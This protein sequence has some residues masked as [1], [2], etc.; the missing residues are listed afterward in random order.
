MNVLLVNTCN[1]WK[2]RSSM[3]LVGIVE[4]EDLA[5]MLCEMIKNKVIEV[6]AINIYADE[7]EKVIDE[8]AVLD[9]LENTSVDMLNVGIDYL[10]IYEGIVG[11]ME[12]NGGYLY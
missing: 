3:H 1:E 9:Y 10:Y 12:T 6:N 11:E 2:E 8:D 5:E 4:K 7:D